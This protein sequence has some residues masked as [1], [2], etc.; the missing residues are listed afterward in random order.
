M[1]ENTETIIEFYLGDGT[2]S[3]GRRIEDI[4]MWD[5]REIENVHNFIQWL[6]PL[7]EVSSFNRSAPTLNAE[8]IETFNSSSELKNNLL[9]SFD[10]MLGFYGYRRM[11]DRDNT[12]IIK[13]ESY[14][15]RKMLWVTPGNHN[16]LRITRILK[17]MSALGQNEYALEF[18]Y[19][20]E[21]L[22]QQNNKVIGDDTFHYWKEAIWN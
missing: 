14:N 11:K 1:V 20:L 8:V 13:T 2:D 12:S 10:M 4:W 17:S 3:L 5:Y 6:F 16:F 22:Y 9:K 21:E 7:R 19:V 15:Q 18:F